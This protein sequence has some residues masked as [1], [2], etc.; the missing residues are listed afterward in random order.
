MSRPKAKKVSEREFQ[1]RPATPDD[2]T[3]ISSL[4]REAFAEFEHDYTREAFEVV[5]PPAEEIVSR[6]DEGPI[7]IAL[8]GEKIVGTVSVVPEP[9]WLYIRSMAVSP[10]AQG[11]GIA[12]KLLETVEEYGL[13]NGF[14]TLFLYTTRFSKDAVRLYKKYGF[15][16]VRYTSGEEWYG[17]PG[18]AMEKGISRN[19]K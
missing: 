4:L 11:I 2:A 17:T 18:I 12:R 9:D 8:M 13:E 15:T 10:R 3:V 14:Y 7:W 5:T 19:R 16:H 1:I 6:F